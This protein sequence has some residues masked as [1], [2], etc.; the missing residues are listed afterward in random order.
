MAGFARRV[1]VAAAVLGL[2]AAIAVSG[3][4]SGLDKRVPPP[5]PPSSS[6]PAPA[7]SSGQVAVAFTFASSGAPIDL[8]NRELAIIKQRIASERLSDTT[9]SVNRDGRGL[10]VQGPAADKDRLEMLGR[11]GVLGFRPVLATSAVRTAVAGSAP[12]GVSAAL[13]QQF[14]T[15]DCT[16]APPADEQLS[17]QIVACQNDG[18][19]KF[20]LDAT[21]VSGTSVT[22]ATASPGAG[23]IWQVNVSLNT[24]G[25]SLFSEL[26]SRLAATGQQIAICVDGVVYSAPT[27]Q[28]TIADG[29]MQISGRFD[30]STA[31]SL[32]AILQNGELPAALTVSSVTG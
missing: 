32:A 26:T 17:A 15:L 28:Q 18:S 22:S 11:A 24:L 13:W 8:L 14:A 3:C 16:S 27:V 5:A 30:Q 20:V 29:E 10:V 12:Q 2:G 25:A 4:E 7:V 1:P 19:A 6:Q 23:G 9:V 31:Q 21:A